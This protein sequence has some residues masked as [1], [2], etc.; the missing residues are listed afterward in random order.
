MEKSHL[1][2]AAREVVGPPGNMG[3]DGWDAMAK[4]KD[5]YV[6]S[7]DPKIPPSLFVSERDRTRHN[8]PIPL[9]ERVI[10][11]HAVNQNRPSQD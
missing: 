6:K 8:I 9:S 3:S 1:C 4:G 11:D 5:A 2:R 10:E 7:F